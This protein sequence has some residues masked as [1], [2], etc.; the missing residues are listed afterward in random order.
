MIFYDL[1]DVI[2]VIWSSVQTIRKE[3]LHM[4]YW[5]IVQLSSCGTIPDAHFKGDA[6]PDD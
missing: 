5:I 4:Y 3:A 6:N 1:A 2:I